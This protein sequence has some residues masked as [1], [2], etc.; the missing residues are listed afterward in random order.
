MRARRSRVLDALA[1]LGLASL[2]DVL[3][4]G[5]FTFHVGPLRVSAHDAL[6]LVLQL[7]LVFGIRRWRTGTF[8][9][10]LEQPFLQ[11]ISTIWRTLVSRPRL[12][13][14]AFLVVVLAAAGLWA[15][16]PA[17]GLTARYFDNPTWSGQPF[18]TTRDAEPTLAR[19]APPWFHDN[20]S[21]EWTGVLDIEAAGDYVFVLESDDGATLQMGDE[22]VVD[23]SGPHSVVRS[24]GQKTL[25][26]GQY[27]I[28]IRFTQTVGSFALRAAW[29]P[30][31]VAGMDPGER[32]FTEARLFAA[33][34]SRFAHQ[35]LR[36]EEA[37]EAV[38]E[39]LLALLLSGCIFSIGILRLSNGT[40]GIANWPRRVAAVV[41]TMATWGRRRRMPVIGVAA[42]AGVAALAVVV[43]DGA[44]RGMTARYFS[45]A[46]PEGA[47]VLVT[48]DPFPRRDRLIYDFSDADG[49]TS[50]IWSGVIHLPDAGDYRFAVRAR[51]R[52]RVSIDGQV[53]VE[54]S[55]GTSE[56]A[57]GTRRLTPGFHLIRVDY[58]DDRNVGGPFEVRWGY[59]QEPMRRLSAATLL[60]ASP[61]RSPWALAAFKAAERT[62]ALVWPVACGMAFVLGGATLLRLRRHVALPRLSTEFLL[63]AALL[64]IISGIYFWASS[65]RS[66][67]WWAFAKPGWWEPFREPIVLAAFGCVVLVAA[68]IASQARGRSAWLQW[69]AASPR[70]RLAVSVAVASIAAVIF[71]LFRSGFVNIDGTS[72][73]WM[74]PDVV[75]G[76]FTASVDEMLERQVHAWLW[77]LTHGLWGWSV[78]LTYQ[79]TSAVAGALFLL[80]LWPLSR[81]L[82][83][84]APRLFALLVLGG[85]YLQ[86]F[87]GEVEH[88]SLVAV[89][90]LGYIYLA[91]RHL[92]GEV[93]LVA[94]TMALALAMSFH[95]LA[96]FLAPSLVFLYARAMRRGALTPIV[97][98]TLAAALVLIVT[99]V[100]VDLPLAALYQGSAGTRA[101]RLLVGAALPGDAFGE[102]AASLE[103]NWAFLAWDEYHW[104]QYNVLALLFPAHLA[105]LLLVA[106]GRVRLDCINA[107]LL[108]AALGMM[109]FHFNYKALL[110]VAHDWNL[111]ANAAIPLVLLTWRC[112]LGASSLA[113]RTMIVTGWLAVSWL[114]TLAWVLLNHRHEP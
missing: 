63:H 79:V 12:A 20:F 114:S 18:L 53:V 76:R 47:P 55:G 7:A 107:F 90:I 98:A 38:G 16:L 31:A 45:T 105:F 91:V 89:A 9:S 92:N 106:A 26:P 46:E 25:Q 21:I 87:F 78:R 5:G 29:N 82:A 73:R 23:N 19:T 96:G 83:P 94:P 58:Q 66:A 81:R 8:V 48:R 57:E 61:E 65:T 93:S 41:H 108:A 37:L 4:L 69:V 40:A 72:Y 42:A 13:A 109:F 33:S 88:Y 60:R 52:V 100:I 50:V 75:A 44:G 30:V 39:L 17:S 77:Q 34:P 43:I 2:I 102:G 62:R 111:F 1:W 84:G 35:V 14:G 36:A 103:S 86:L 10:G 74:I 27:P 99:V 67:T 28:A 56:D 64:G 6:P 80:V 104:N 113:G 71:F 11:V 49:V 101:M 3:I 51:T 85:G 95:M 22:I 59:G 110:P 112:F 68:A 15:A 70:Q 32:P 24:E 97:L 54:R